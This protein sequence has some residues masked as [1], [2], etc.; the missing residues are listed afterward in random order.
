MLGTLSLMHSIKLLPPFSKHAIDQK[1]S[2]YNPSFLTI[3]QSHSCKEI[4][5]TFLRAK[6]IADAVL[7]YVFNKGFPASLLNIFVLIWC[8]E[9]YNLPYLSL[10]DLLWLG[11]MYFMYANASSSNSFSETPNFSTNADRSTNIF[12]FKKKIY[13]ERL[14]IFKAQRVGPQMHQ[15]TSQT[16][17]T[18]GSSTRAIWNNSLFLRLY[19]LVDKCTSP[20]VEHLPHVNNK[21]MQ[22]RGGGELR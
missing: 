1:V 17:P 7:L 3:I 22:S 21:C 19:E 16:P 20:L 9:T 8:F 2:A 12:L 15:S 18:C 5:F 13:P 6:E 10:E 11:K 4:L 14:L